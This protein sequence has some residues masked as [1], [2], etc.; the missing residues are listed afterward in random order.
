MFAIVVSSCIIKS[1]L[2]NIY[3]TMHVQLKLLSNYKVWSVLPLVWD[4]E[5]DKGGLMG[6]GVVVTITKS[7]YYVGGSWRR[8][9]SLQCH[10]S[11]QNL[12]NNFL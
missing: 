8:G 5:H 7:H 4:S 1:K 6:V 3:T 12:K 9:G 10:N 11:R 2:V